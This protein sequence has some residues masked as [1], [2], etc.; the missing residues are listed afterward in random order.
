MFSNENSCKQA[1]LQSRLA[2]RGTETSLKCSK[3]SRRDMIPILCSIH[4]SPMIMSRFVTDI[5]IYA[6][7]Y[8]FLCSVTFDKRSNRSNLFGTS[9]ECDRRCGLRKRLHA[10]KNKPTLKACHC[11][12]TTQ[13]QPLKYLRHPS[14]D[15]GFNL[16]VNKVRRGE[17]EANDSCPSSTD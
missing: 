17:I 3:C 11:L 1:F 9:V 10:P 2:Q 8:T 5:V 16:I 14:L 12:I 6:I 7:R 13:S 15:K 4:S